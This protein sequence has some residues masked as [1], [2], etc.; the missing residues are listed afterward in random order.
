MKEAREKEMGLTLT[1]GAALEK[2]SAWVCG[3]AAKRTAWAPKCVVLHTMA[4]G[5][6]EATAVPL[7]LQAG[8]VALVS[9]HRHWGTARTAGQA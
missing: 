3:R 8:G 2:M 4:V 5:T 6:T 1:R 9:Y 7:T